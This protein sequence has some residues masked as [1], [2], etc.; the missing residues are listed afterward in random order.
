MRGSE[1]TELR[2]FAAIAREG[3]FVRAAASLRV[4]PSALSQTI[5]QLEERVGV[6]LLNRT[7]RSVAP[8]AAGE[9]LL[10]RLVPALAELE[11]AVTEVTELRDRPMG[12]LRINAARLP[13]TRIL[14]PLL[15]RFRDAY[16]DVRLE[17]FTDDA[18]TDIVA[19]HFDAGIRLG[20]R[21]DKDMVALKL[22]EELSMSAVAAP[23]YLAANGTP[24]SPRE[25]PKHRCINWRLPSG[26]LY[27]WELGRGADEVEVAVDGPL[28]VNDTDL[29]LDA[30][31]G[32]VGIAFV[33]D[34]AAAPHVAS[35]R[36]VRLLERWSPKFPGFFLYYPK[37]RHIRP[38][39]RAFVAFL[40]AEATG[41]TAISPR[42]RARP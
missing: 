10:E 17:I 37:Q 22:G 35:G 32:G 8:S 31:I 33:F 9:R 26:A 28:V 21:V 14:G 6:R 41:N 1:Y 20:E 2:A 13:A 7:T 11:G 38:A 29:A 24:S 23:A 15:G 34:V 5:R 12:D 18:I 27:R 19:S 30:A 4:S 25:L 42:K 3:S 16:P 40:R 39:L 36:L